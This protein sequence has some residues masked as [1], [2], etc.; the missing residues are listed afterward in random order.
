MNTLVASA[1]GELEHAREVLRDAVA[2]ATTLGQLH[3]F[4][5]DFRLQLRMLAD[6]DVRMAAERAVDEVLTPAVASRHEQLS[7]SYPTADRRLEHT[8]RAAE[9]ER[10]S[11]RDTAAPDVARAV[12]AHRLQDR[13]ILQPPL[14]CLYEELLNTPLQRMA[15]IGLSRV[16]VRRSDEL[17]AAR[18]L[19][20]LERVQGRLVEL[21]AI[22][23]VDRE[24]KVSP[25]LVVLG[26]ATEAQERLGQAVDGLTARR[27]TGSVCFRRARG[28]G[29][30]GWGHGGAGR[31]Q[32]GAGQRAARE[33]SC[34]AR[35]SST[36]A[37]V[38]VELLSGHIGEAQRD[39]SQALA[40][41]NAAGAFQAPWLLIQ[42]G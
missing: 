27:T 42:G 26:R 3:Q 1:R 13:G 36:C 18:D 15:T 4:D 39:I 29:T 25:V 19:E 33:S 31:L 9:A 21:G 35:H 34:P 11:G 17:V 16:L 37:S 30:G 28:G 32:R 8:L 41:W 20:G 40:G 7:T 23:A 10:E 12:L 14:F 38:L 24:L 2:N 5:C 22:R 6:D